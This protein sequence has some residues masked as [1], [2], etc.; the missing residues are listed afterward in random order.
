MTFSQIVM[1]IKT[2]QNALICILRQDTK[3]HHWLKP[4]SKLL[5]HYVDT[6]EMK[7]Y[8]EGIVDMSSYQPIN[9]EIPSVVIKKRIFAMFLVY[10][11]L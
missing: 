5:F 7:L 9:Q 10:N 2:K 6:L 8:T 11:V 4:D 1:Y 3:H